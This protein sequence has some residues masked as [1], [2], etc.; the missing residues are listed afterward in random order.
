MQIKVFFICS[1]IQNREWQYLWW[2]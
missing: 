1:I 2:S